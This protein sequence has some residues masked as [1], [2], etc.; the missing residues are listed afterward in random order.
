MIKLTRKPCP[1]PI[2]LKTNYKIKA[3]KQVLKESAYSKCM[4][5]ESKLDHT[6]YGDVEHIKPK[7]VFPNDKY[8]WDNLG[9]ACEK[10]NRQYKKE[11]YDP[12]FIN[13][14]I[15]NPKDYLIAIG[16]L[17]FP[18]SGN[19]R[20][21]ITI[22]ILQLN[23]AE[24]LSKRNDVLKSFYDLIIRYHKA[25]SLAQKEAIK[26]SIED[27]FNETKEYSACKESFWEASK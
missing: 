13:P 5:C 7:S 25:I 22:D 12:N 16:G 18:L 11:K 1:D 8:N 4:Y 9:Y 21:E 17:F 27:E 6:E 15:D 24:L 26:L 2:G 20:G 10:C 23:R 14:F 3:N 19:I